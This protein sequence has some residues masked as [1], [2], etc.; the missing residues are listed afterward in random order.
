MKFDKYTFTARLYP[1]IICLLPFLVFAINCKIDG[2]E[3]SFNN[4][5]KIS[6]LGNITSSIVLLYSLIQKNR[7]LGKFLLE[8]LIFNDELNMPT[9][10]FLLYS[11]NEF[12]DQYKDK[13]RQKV[14]TNYRITIN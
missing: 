8:K 5:L 9:T 2:L 11:D 4:L 1:A 7:F 12:S 3:S 14:N 10:R 13:I 6:I